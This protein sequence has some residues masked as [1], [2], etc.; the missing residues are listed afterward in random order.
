MDLRIRKIVVVSGGFDPFHRGHLNLL[1]SAKRLG[2]QL[3]VIVESDEWVSSK[4]PVTMPQADRAAIIQELECVDLVLLNQKHGDCSEVLATVRPDI[5]VVGPDHKD[6]T[7]I[8]EFEACR[9]L[10]I[11]ITCMEY[12]NKDR[13]SSQ[14]V[15]NL[16]EANA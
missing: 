6:W 9:S 11:K 1:L 8:P 7:V 3:V 12:L 16:M 5:Y 4:H 13:S 14:I 15:S 10:G 2:N